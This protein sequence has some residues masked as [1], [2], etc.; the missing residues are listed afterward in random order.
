MSRRQLLAVGGSIGVGTVAGCLEGTSG[1][2]SSDD[3]PTPPWTTDELASYI[4]TNAEITIYA[5]TGSDGQW[6]DLVE[7]INDEFGTDITANVF[8]SNGAKVTQRFRQERQAGEDRVDLL[9]SPSGIDDK[10]RVLAAEEDKETALELGKEYFEW[11]L[12]QK[13]WFGDVLD[14][15]QKYPFYVTGYNGG[16]GL[17]LPINEDIFEERGLDIP[18]T[19]NDLLD[20]Q[21]EGLDTLMAG[22]VAADMVGWIVRHHAAQTDMTEKE[23]ANA[24]RDNLNFVGTSS[25]TAGVREV[26][27]GDAPMMLYNWTTVPAPFISAESPLR[28]VFPEDV[29]AFINGSPL[30][31]NKEAPNPWVARFFLSALLEEPVQRRMIHDVANQIPCR[32]DIDYS[33]EEMDPY[34]EKRLTAD[35]EP[36]GFWESFENARTGQRLKDTGVFDV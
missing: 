1:S 29:K 34:T 3:E 28:G 12:D 25:H 10:M 33:T 21:Y 13:F 27:N 11:D 9:S 23:W 2:A 17:V 6:Y 26:R 5:S 19:Y 20:S 36:V 16:P 35:F 32:F 30:A 4:D 22:Y 15:V 24:L 7:V 31:I 8:A 14:D 18:E